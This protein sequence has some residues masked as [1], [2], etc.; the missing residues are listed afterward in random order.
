MIKVEREAISA[1]SAV[2]VD[3]MAQGVR[4][5]CTLHLRLYLQNKLLTL[6]PGSGA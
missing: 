6:Q 3:K 4:L 1:S 2:Q 5:G